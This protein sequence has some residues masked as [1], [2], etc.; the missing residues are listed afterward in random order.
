MAAL[1]WLMNLDF[2]GGAAPVQPAAGAG[3]AAREAQAQRRPYRQQYG[4]R[5]IAPFVGWLLW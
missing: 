3:A 5:Y 2:A 1:G 4:Y